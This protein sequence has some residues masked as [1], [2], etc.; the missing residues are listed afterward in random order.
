[1]RLSLPKPWPT[2]NAFSSH[3]VFDGLLVGDLFDWQGFDSEYKCKI[4]TAERAAVNVL[5]IAEF[6]RKGQWVTRTKRLVQMGELN[7]DLIKRWF[8]NDLL[9][10]SGEQKRRKKKKNRVKW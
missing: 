3:G 10:H 9:R 6:N 1:M 8:E 5:W 4:T 2:T 7:T